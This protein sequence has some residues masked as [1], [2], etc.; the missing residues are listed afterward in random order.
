MAWIRAG[1]SGGSGGIPF[2]LTVTCEE[3]FIGEVL[4]FSNGITILT[5]TVPSSLTVVF[6]IPTAGTWTLSN[7]L[8]SDT[9]VFNITSEYTAELS[10]TPDGKTVLPTDD[11]QTWLKCAGISD[12]SYTTLAEVLADTDTLLALITSDNAIDYMVRSKTWAVAQALVP[13]MTSDTTPSG[14]SSAS[15]CYENSLAYKA[16][17][18]DDT[19]RWESANVSPFVNVWI[20]Y[21]FTEAITVESFKML[22]PARNQPATFTLQGS[23]DGSSF[24]DVETYSNSTASSINVTYNNTD[25]TA[26]RYWRILITSIHKDSASSSYWTGL[27]TLQFYSPSITT[28]ATAMQYINSYDYAATTLLADSDWC[29][30][31]CNS[32]YS[33]SVLNVKN[34]TMTS[35]TTPSGVASASGTPAN[36]WKALDG[37]F[38]NA[39]T[40]SDGSSTSGYLQYHFPTPKRIN[41]VP[42]CPYVTSRGLSI[43]QFSISASNDNFSTSDTL[44]TSEVF[45]NT[46]TI[47]DTFTM[48]ATFLNTT[49]YSDYRLNI[50]STYDTSKYI[51]VR[52]CL[53]IGRENSG[54]QTWLHAAG[55]TDKNYTTLAE[56][57]NDTTTLAALMAS[58]DAVDYL[59]TCKEWASTIS[60]PTMTSNTAPSGRCFAS[61]EYSGRGAY[62]AFDG[63]SNAWQTSNTS[64]SFSNIYVGYQ[65]T[66]A[67]E[68][69]RAA[70]TVGTPQVSAMTYKFQG[71]SD[72][73][74]WTDLTS[75]LTTYSTSSTA[76]TFATTGKFSYYRML[77]ISQTHSTSER[78]GMISALQFYSASITDNATAMSYIGLNNYCANTL[79][80]DSTWRNAI[81]NSEYFESVLN[82]KVPVMTSNTTP[83]GIASASS[84]D[85]DHYAYK[86]MDGNDGSYWFCRTSD[87]TLGYDFGEPKNVYM[88]VILQSSQDSN[89][90]TYTEKIQS[91]TDGVTW[92]DESTAE[93]VS[94][95]TTAKTT[96]LLFAA[97]NKNAYRLN[98][99]SSQGR[100]PAVFTIQFYGRVDV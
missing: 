44:Y 30:A 46:T 93:S 56:V 33:G 65:F 45:A 43:K 72:G 40:H 73:S 23:N 79:L 37:D 4:T 91:S 35:N 7:S 16:F 78:G 49:E 10:A 90:R 22:L 84:Y 34:P 99:T 14:E 88:A 61:S 85:S 60:V 50:L 70:F 63:T 54:V 82:V 39:W 15:T 69:N 8:T 80:A 28:S 53:F 18:G 76:V 96:K 48:F 71:S 41:R 58:E 19:T 38:S 55:I 68:I 59:V 52:E 83:S 29:E 89:T 62:V 12:K 20:Q 64:T 26:Y 51:G 21:D 6:S 24:A 92:N 11:I 75:D 67:I 97:N 86:A 32:E 98:I 47:P 13:M 5:E 9:E 36:A 31:I 27:N 57:L 95:G 2:T 94:T 1:L 25:V 74:A 100:S 66:S 81:C 87:S 77:I 42:I 17:D 3:D